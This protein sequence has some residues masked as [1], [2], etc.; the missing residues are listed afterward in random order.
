[1]S[2]PDAKR[3]YRKRRRHRE[4]ER[5]LNHIESL[6]GGPEQIQQDLSL[7]TMLRLRLLSRT[8]EWPRADYGIPYRDWVPFDTPVK[9]DKPLMGVPPQPL[10]LEGMHCAYCGKPGGLLCVEHNPWGKPE[11]VT[12]RFTPVVDGKMGDPL[13]PCRICERCVVRFRGMLCVDCELGA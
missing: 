1:M 10:T 5:M 9:L 6:L 7:A 8:G 4:I 12:V 13:Y 3:R 2:K 11:G